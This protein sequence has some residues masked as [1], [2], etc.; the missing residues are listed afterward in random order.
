MTVL[1][2]FVAIELSDLA[3][4]RLGELAAKLERAVPR[5]SVRWVPPANIHLTLRFLGDTDVE[6][7]P[8]LQNSLDASAAMHEPLT[9][10][11]GELGCFPNRRRPRVLWV[12]VQGDTESLRALRADVETGVQQ[13]GIEAERRRFHPHLTLGRARD[14]Q[15]VARAD[16]PWGKQVTPENIEIQHL[17]LIQSDLQ[18]TGAV[19]TTLHESRVGG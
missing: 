3:R 11:L 19:Y 13:L 12:G 5:R 6:I 14:S 7:L 8:A 15:A 1:R 16:L 9:L 17:A 10:Q 18:L 2:V 4:E